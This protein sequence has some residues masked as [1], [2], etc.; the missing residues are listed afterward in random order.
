MADPKWLFEILPS[1]SILMKFS[2]GAVFRSLITNLV[3]VFPKK[4][5][6]DPKW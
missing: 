5:M 3:F 1:L 6:A 4:E 2:D